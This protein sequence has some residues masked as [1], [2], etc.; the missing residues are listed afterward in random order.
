VTPTFRDLFGR[1]PETSAQAPGRVNLIGEHTDYNDGFVLPMT[2]PQHT[3]VELARSDTNVVRVWSANQPDAAP[4]SYELGRETRTHTWIDYPQ[5]VTAVLAEAGGELVGLD[6]RIESTIPLGSG[7]SSSAALLVALVRAIREAFGFEFSDVAAARFAHRAET[8]LVGAPVGIMDQMVCS[9]GRP[10]AALLLDTRS[11]EVE[12]VPLPPALDLVVI[13]SG[14]HHAHAGGEYRTRRAECEEA[15]RRLGV[16]SLRDV[17]PSAESLAQI[18][19]LPA[20]LSRR[21]R[22]VITENVR[23]R[24]LVAALATQNVER[25]G[26]LLQAGHASLRDDFEVSTPEVDALVELTA[27]TPGILGARMTGGGFGG[28]IVALAEAGTGRRAAE[29]AATA[30]TARTGRH[31]TVLLPSS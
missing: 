26:A 27:A 29:Q 25:I 1:E 2:I 3:R 15:A 12:H 19:G 23:V 7:L 9:V 20:P 22:H 18:E 28:S 14:V 24:A 5:G 16:A 30:Y 11:L 8:T 4:L 6:L 10:G 31:A 13:D 21:A 17:P